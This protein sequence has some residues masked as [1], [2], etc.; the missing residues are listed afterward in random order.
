MRRRCANG[1]LIAMTDAS[2]IA[3]A[4][5]T[6]L[7][8]KFD[9]AGRP[10]VYWLNGTRAYGN[11]RFDSR[12]IVRNHAEVPANPALPVPAQPPQQKVPPPSSA[13]NVPLNAARSVIKTPPTGAAPSSRPGAKMGYDWPDVRDLVFKTMDSNGE[14]NEWDVGNSWTCQADLERLVMEYLKNKPSESTVRKHV[15][16]FLAEWRAKDQGANN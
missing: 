16:K 11:I 5:W 15:K 4:E 3:R 13:N 12:E 8:I 7:N 2:P 6:T 14:F 9:L 1:E 10:G